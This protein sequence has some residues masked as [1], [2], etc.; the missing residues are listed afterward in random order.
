MRLFKKKKS[1]MLKIEKTELV[2]TSKK[3]KPV[4]LTKLFKDNNQVQKS[5]KVTIQK[6]KT[7]RSTLRMTD[8]SIGWVAV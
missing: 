1:R 8:N 7:K 5:E 6:S 2:K 4:D 3:T